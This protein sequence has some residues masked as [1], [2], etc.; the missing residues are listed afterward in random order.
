M[1]NNQHIQLVGVKELQ[2]SMNALAPE[3]MK[4]AERAVLRAGAAPILKAAKQNAQ[5]SRDSGLLY[6]SLGVNVKKVRGITDA[7]IGPRT[8]MRQAVS[9][10]GK[11][12]RIANPA[13]YSHLVEY[14]T[15]HSA[16]K[17]FIRPAVDSASPKVVDAMAQGLDK[18][19]TRTAA[20]LARR[21]KK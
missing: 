18:Y 15:S 6:K 16:A 11:P 12:P 14:G 20:R 21:A 8:G 2:R 3:L 5:S 19:L 7:R 4:S 10:D 13:N 1:A 17:P 9:R